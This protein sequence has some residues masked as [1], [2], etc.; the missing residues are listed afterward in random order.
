MKRILSA[1]MMLSMLLA[2]AACGGDSVATPTFSTQIVSDPAFDGDIEITTQNIATVTQGMS[3]PAVQS[4]FAGIDAISET[5]AFLNFPLTGADGVPGNAVIVSA[6][7]DIII[8]SFQSQA[9]SIPIRIELV[10]FQPP[11]LIADDFD[12]AILL[13]RDFI[14]T[15][16]FRSDSGNRVLIDVTPL[17]E[18][19]Q[20]RGQPDFQV[21]ILEDLGV[22]TPG[23]IEIDDTTATPADRSN[24]APALEVTYF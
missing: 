10:D 19:A 11:T 23:V 9:N 14:Q 18:E 2:L 1:V 17:M 16:I 4:V 3:F 12:R 24:F 13:P 8:K 6:T 7:L 15:T 5:R 21:R 22:V 20:F